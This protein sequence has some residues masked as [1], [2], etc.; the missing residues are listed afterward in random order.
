MLLLT[1]KTASKTM[2]TLPD[3]WHLSDGLSCRQLSNRTKA[4]QGTSLLS[5]FLEEH[6]FQKDGCKVVGKATCRDESRSGETTNKAR[7]KPNT[8]NSRLSKSVA[9]PSHLDF[10]CF[11]LHVGTFLT[12]LMLSLNHHGSVRIPNRDLK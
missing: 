7:R 3:R 6:Y 4:T 9:S 2:A 1:K 8:T 10:C 5:T 12:Q 11:S